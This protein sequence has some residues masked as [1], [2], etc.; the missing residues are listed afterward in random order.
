MVRVIGGMSNHWMTRAMDRSAGKQH[1]PEMLPEY[2]LKGRKSV[3]GKYHQAYRS[4]YT[5][6]VHRDDGAVMSQQFMPKEKSPEKVMR[7]RPM[8]SPV[9]VVDRSKSGRSSRAVVASVQR[10]EPIPRGDIGAYLVGVFACQPLTM[11]RK[12]YN[13]K[14]KG[15]WRHCLYKKQWRAALQRKDV[16][17]PE[18][19][20]LILIGAKLLREQR[21]PHGWGS[22]AVL[23]RHVRELLHKWS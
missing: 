16:F 13:L 6:R 21:R 2:D 8:G 22:Q 12:D 19:K 3:R 9:E 4:G 23:Q 11:D 14:A 17:S 7:R 15:P 1:F 18:E 10:G 20:E 5:V